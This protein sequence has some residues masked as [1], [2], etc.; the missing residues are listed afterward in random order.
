MCI[1]KR[2]DIFSFEFW[3]HGQGLLLCTSSC[4][5]VF[6]LINLLYHLSHV[7]PLAPKSSNFLQC[8]NWIFMLF[9]LW[10]FVSNWVVYNINRDNTPQSLGFLS[11]LKEKIFMSVVNVIAIFIYLQNVSNFP[12]KCWNI[13]FSAISSHIY[14]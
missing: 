9:P 11:A 7:S 4:C 12:N 3:F 5:L 6:G 1:L 14:F 2:D 8:Q 10:Y 13:L